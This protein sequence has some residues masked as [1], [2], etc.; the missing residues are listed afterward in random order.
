MSLVALLV[1]L[2]TSTVLADA[3]GL[4]GAGLPPNAA[5]DAAHAAAADVNTTQ[6]ASSATLAGEAEAIGAAVASS[7]G[8]HLAAGGN[9]SSDAAVMPL[10]ES[11]SENMSSFSAAAFDQCPWY[12]WEPQCH[13]KWFPW[14]LPCLDPSYV[15]PYM[16]W[17]AKCQSAGAPAPAPAPQNGGGFSPSGNVKTLY[18]QTSPQVAALILKGAFKA[19]TQGWCGGGI[20]FATSPSATFGKAIGPNSHN[21]EILEV[22][23]DLG[24]TLHMPSTC[25]RSLNSAEVAAKGF[26][27]VTFNPGDGEEYIIYDASRVLSKQEYHR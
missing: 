11:V 3:G 16:P 20:Y 14:D 22:K 17:L 23:V 6:A 26:D 24:R 4:R 1:S 18:H 8:Q 21:G 19:G 5:E 12:S 15:C 7:P 25:D 27:S 13:C 10:A 9:A 2:F